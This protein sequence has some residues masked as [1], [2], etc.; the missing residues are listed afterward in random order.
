MPLSA[1]SQEVI[2]A[3]LPAVGAA[4]G[5]MTPLF[6][7]KMFAEHPELERNLFNRGKQKQGEQHK[8]LAGS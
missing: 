3:T 8:A 1:E 2:R 4:I 6:Y 7:K 5:D